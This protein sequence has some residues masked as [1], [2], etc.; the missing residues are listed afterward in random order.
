MTSIAIIP[1][2][3]EE[4]TIGNVIVRLKEIVDQVVV[5]DDNSDDNT[6]AIAIENGA[7]VIR[8]MKNMGYNSSLN[9]GFKFALEQSADEVLTID[10][11][12]H[13]DSI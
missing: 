10:A 7:Y 9:K 3:N 8:N 2:L 12:G 4:L 11:D 6:K 5:I 1:A 13:H